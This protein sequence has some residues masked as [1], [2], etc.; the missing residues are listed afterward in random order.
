MAFGRGE[1]SWKLSDEES[2]E[3]HPRFWLRTSRKRKILRMNGKRDLTI[4]KLNGVW[5]FLLSVGFVVIYKSE[6]KKKIEWVGKRFNWW[7]QRQSW[8]PDEQKNSWAAVGFV[9]FCKWEEAGVSLLSLLS[10]LLFGSSIFS[11]EIFVTFFWL[12]A[13]LKL[14]LTQ[15]RF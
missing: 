13:S 7:T 12:W 8:T 4:I 1:C 11:T 2:F 10:N 15:N 9:C 14:P 6:I 3:S 5:P